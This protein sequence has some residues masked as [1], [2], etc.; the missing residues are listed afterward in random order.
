MQS[1]RTEATEN[2][3]SSINL[4][5]F[6]SRYTDSD[7]ESGISIIFPSPEIFAFNHNL[8]IL[9][10][11]ANKIAFKSPRWDQRPDYCSYDSYNTVIFWPLILYINQIDTM[12]DFVGLD[13]VLIPPFRTILEILKDKVP[14]NTPQEL[15]KP[16]VDA[17]VRFYKLFPLDDKEEEKRQSEKR[18]NEAFPEVTATEDPQYIES[19]EEFLTTF[20]MMYLKYLDLAHIP[21]S[22]SSITMYINDISIPL[23]FGYDYILLKNE[24]GE[25]RRINWST[26]KCVYGQGLEDILIFENIKIKII[27]LYSSEEIINICD[28]ASGVVSVDGSFIG[29]DTDYILDG[30]TF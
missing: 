5:N 30:G 6:R 9:L 23:Q 21:A 24:I 15:E 16:K 4:D 28:A 12:E 3:A 1:I 18:M 8:F 10:S 29:T 20:D 7:E 27:Y 22:T 26:D 11:E 19:T 17:S 2:S 13:Y 25:Y 14:F